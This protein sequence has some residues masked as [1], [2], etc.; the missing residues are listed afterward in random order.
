VL[1]EALV[2]R[3][4]DV[5]ILLAPKAAVEILV[6]ESNDPAFNPELTVSVPILAVVKVA[7]D[8]PRDAVVILVVAT[9]VPVV[10]LGI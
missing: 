9:R 8:A 1:P 2:K 4:V 5:V 10:R 7:L 3:K 6:L